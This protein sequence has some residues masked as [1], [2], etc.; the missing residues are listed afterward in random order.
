MGPLLQ[1]IRF[2]ARTLR[3]R[4]GY[5][6]V[7]VLTLALGI[8]ATTAIF[9]VVDA[10]PLRP[11]PYPEADRV[12]MVWESNHARGLPYMLASPAN[13]ADWRAE[14]VDD[15][16]GSR[17]VF[18]AMGAYVA[19]DLTVTG[20]DG[21]ERVAGARVSADML[22]LLGVEPVVGRLFD[23]SDDRPGAPRVAVL[24]HGL[25]QGYF[26]GSPDATS[27]REGRRGSIR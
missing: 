19:A 24:S 17:A 8:G 5:A 16:A 27:R 7:A 25:W 13:F 20:R 2:A 21:A 15:G 26:A 9:S 10:V 23:E 1:D 18:D 3:K 4:P 6:A 12:V 14:A 22:T 11:L